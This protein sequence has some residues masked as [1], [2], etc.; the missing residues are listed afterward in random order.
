MENKKNFLVF[1]EDNELGE[2]LKRYFF[3]SENFQCEQYTFCNPNQIKRLI[4]N[5]Y[6]LLV[7]DLTGSKEDKFDDSN[8]KKFI[9]YLLKTNKIP[10]TLIINPEKSLNNYVNF[11][12][13]GNTYSFNLFAF[14]EIFYEYYNLLSFPFTLDN[15]KSF[16]KNLTEFKN[17]FYNLERRIKEIKKIF[18]SLRVKINDSANIIAEAGKWIYEENRREMKKP[19]GHGKEE[20]PPEEFKPEMWFYYLLI[21]FLFLQKRGKPLRILWL[22]N[23]PE[24]K[25]CK[26]DKN[27]P[28][29]KLS[30]IDSRL[31]HIFKEDYSI[32]DIMKK[33]SE[34]L[35]NFEV[36]IIEKEFKKVYSQLMQYN[37]KNKNLKFA[38]VK[39]L[40]NN[41]PRE[42]TFEDLENNY[43]L[44]IIDIFLDDKVDDKIKVNGLD[45]IKAFTNFFPHIPAFILSVC[46]DYEIISDAIK[47]GADFYILKSDI[48]SLP[49][50][51]FL[52]IRKLG[53]VIDFLK[54]EELKKS[55][56]GNIRYWNFKRNLLWFGD[57]CYHMIEHS[58]EHTKD[59]WEIANEILYPL[60]KEDRITI[61]DETLYSFLMTIWLHDIGH[62]GSKKY[63]EPYQIRDNH[64]YL[65]AELIV[66]YP[67]LFR[68][69]NKN[70]ES[71]Q[72]YDFTRDEIGSFVE[73]LFDK[74]SK[75]KT[76][77]IFEKI[78][79][80]TLYHK[81]NCPITMEEYNL[82]VKE[83]KVIPI[84]YY[85]QKIR[86]KNNIIT[87]E[88][89]VN[90]LSGDPDKDFL[91]SLAFL[92]RFIDALDIKVSR[93]G[94]F[95]EENLKKIVIENDKLYLF[96]EK[97]GKEAQRMCSDKSQE[98]LWAKIFVKDVIDKIEQGENVS[99]DD[100]KPYLTAPN[101]L[102][103]YMMLV[104][105]ASFIALQ[106]GH[107]N[108]HSS[109]EKLEINFSDK[110]IINVYLNRTF[111][112]LKKLIINERG[113]KTQT[114]YER[115]VGSKENQT[116]SYYYNEIKTG[117]K[118]LQKILHEKPK[119]T[120]IDVTYK[121]NE[122][123]LVD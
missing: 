39:S 87:F 54:D 69:V 41:N 35:G 108:L 84:E 53:K 26:T 109:V 107:F 73:T 119:I 76:L 110:L 46:D 9:T 74:A 47:G 55:L 16:I 81:S 36:D 13:N 79:L 32:K 52:Y 93:V 103:N 44:I 18:K 99:F 14:T 95:T 20:K 40:K 104:N 45:F 77:E 7:L 115:L 19:S 21:S 120:I 64:G 37:E 33:F 61:R 101:E 42:I 85:K 100:L 2:T 112:E 15:L 24:R 51:Y 43:T 6:F 117:W 25:L 102:E 56:I 105:H 75:R 80:F 22:E 94:D 62:K 30:E 5:N 11:L 78:A 12:S 113:K 50:T 98:L 34:L 122:A 1:S 59:D 83:N 17:P 111:E 92:F 71:Y 3:F 60:L 90:L 38:E 96:N 106:P 27:N 66:Q 57:K 10:N 49:F 65:A 88:E 29:R 116:S 31:T 121:K 67:T 68:I 114:V 4:K 97:L 23:N 86:H 70:N 82:L 91:I 58:F 8:Q 63:G 28:K 72:N 118:Y 48:L 89:I 123:I